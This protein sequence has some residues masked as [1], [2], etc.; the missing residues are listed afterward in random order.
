VVVSVAGGAGAGFGAGAGAG[1]GWGA[2]WGA[3]AP[4]DPDPD[5]LVDVLEVEPVDVGGAVMMTT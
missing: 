2:A 4:S 5:E 1:A 3:A